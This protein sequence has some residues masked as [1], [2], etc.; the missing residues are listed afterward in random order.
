M[1][2]IKFYG[3]MDRTFE[4]SRYLSV[5]EQYGYAL[6]SR[7]SITINNELLQNSCQR[8]CFNIDKLN[9]MGELKLFYDSIR[10]L[11]S[12]FNVIS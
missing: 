6:V 11:G 12:T 1:L 5:F 7:L 4:N 10:L 8:E 3:R 2:K 9:C